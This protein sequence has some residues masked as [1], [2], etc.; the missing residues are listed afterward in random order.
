MTKIR[1]V[2]AD[3]HTLVRSGLRTL[4]SGIEGVEVVGEAANGA[5]ALELARGLVPDVVMMDIA[6]GQMNGLEATRRIRA[7]SPAVRVLI[8]SMHAGEEYVVQALEAGAAGYILKDCAPAEL[9]LALKAVTRGDSYLSP[10]VSRQ[11]VE[12]YVQRTGSGKGR[13]QLSPRQREILKLVA[14]GLSTKQIAHHL[15]VSV[16]TVESHRAQL[17][18]RLRIRDVAGLVRYA[19]RAGLVD[20]D[21]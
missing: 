2:L 19:I 4:V 1:I 6:M 10:R 20:L 12:G 14:E 7:E 15:G 18:E 3:D 16:K 13:E 9:E 17:M 11:I 5:E 8:L 21:S